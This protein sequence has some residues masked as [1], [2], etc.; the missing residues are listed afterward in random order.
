MTRRAG[1]SRDLSVSA[2]RAS[3]PRNW[4][5]VIRGCALNR[6]LAV[7]ANHDDKIKPLRMGLAFSSLTDRALTNRI[8]SWV[9]AYFPRSVGESNPIER[10]NRT[11]IW[12]AWTGT[13]SPSTLWASTPSDP[14]LVTVTNRRRTSK[15]VLRSE[16][17][18]SELQ[19]HHDLVC[20]LLL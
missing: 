8:A 13:P 3:S 19:S 2:A 1:S 14:L 10:M 12:A 5:S 16:E 20:R 6:D 7:S 17:H 9:G 11:F 4:S 18:T 15:C